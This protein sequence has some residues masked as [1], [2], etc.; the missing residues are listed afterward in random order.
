M[1]GIILLGL[2]RYVCEV[3]GE[4]V[5]QKVQA[6]PGLSNRIYL[7]LQRYPEYELQNLVRLISNETHLS[8]SRLLEDFGEHL[9]PEMIR[10]YGPMIDSNWKLMDVLDNL[11]V[12]FQR[13]GRVK[14]SALELQAIMSGSRLS[15]SDGVLLYSGPEGL[16]S[17]IKG[18]VR[19]FAAQR[20]EIAAISEGK[21]MR[22]GHSAC[23]LR[24][25]AI[26]RTPSSVFW[27]S[28]KSGT[29]T[30]LRGNSSG[31][32]QAAVEPRADAGGIGRYSKVAG[33][34]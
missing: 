19:G 29:M 17:L 25:R 16:C 13:I 21:C 10:M 14:K 2:H 6:L 9:M 12:V 28:S 27:A 15:N 11:I 32:Y 24:V 3:L 30:A 18:M 20:N 8:A 5:W 7:P 26:A 33:D 23:E 31:L 1:E 4:P 34:E 22:E